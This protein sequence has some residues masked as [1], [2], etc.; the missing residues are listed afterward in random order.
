MGSF[1]NGHLTL[2]EDDSPVCLRMLGCRATPSGA[3]Q[4]TLHANLL[5]SALGLRVHHRVQQLHGRVKVVLLPVLAPQEGH[6]DLQRQ[7]TDLR[8]IHA[9]SP[10]CL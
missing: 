4:T 10:F 5:V 2:R 9:K 6:G 7:H 8:Q 1:R 3:L